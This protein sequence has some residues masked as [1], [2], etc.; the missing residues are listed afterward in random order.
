MLPQMCS[1]QQLGTLYLSRLA[2]LH[3][4]HRRASLTL[5]VTNAACVYNMSCDA[6]CSIHICDVLPQN[7][8][9]VC[10]CILK[11]RRRARTFSTINPLVA[12]LL[13]NAQDP[14]TSFA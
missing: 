6:A 3:S 12:G 7:R 4:Y 11:P 5:L 1:W 10:R 8:Q 14:H 9:L 13:S 2:G